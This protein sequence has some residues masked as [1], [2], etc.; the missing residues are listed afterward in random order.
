MIKKFIVV[1]LVLSISVLGIACNDDEENP[2]GAGV[3]PSASALSGTVATNSTNLSWTECPDDDFASY[4][5]YRSETSGIAA[6]PSAATMITTITDAQTLIYTDLNLAWE[7]NY[8]YAL[9]TVDSSQLT[10]WSNEISITTPDSSGGGGGSALTCY[11]IQGQA[12]E[13]PY[14]GEDV[15]VTG[16]VTAGGNEYYGGT[17]TA[18][19]AVIEDATGGEWSGLVLYGYDGILTG[20]VRG[21]SVVVSGYVS[22]YNGLTEV[23]VNTID[24]DDPGHT[25]PA[26]A[27]ISTVDVDLEKWEGVL[28]SVSNVTVTDDDLGYGEWYVD[29]GSGDGRV[30]DLGDYSYS[31]SNGDTFTEI[32]GVI[33][34]SFT[35]YKIEPRDDSDLI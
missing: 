21:D 16:I 18:Q 27:A 6:N 13:S 9:K 19:Y 28:I 32:I 2:Q 20:L 23:V 8:Y 7:T 3:N 24:F 30:D 10:S 25:I 12:D 11:Q 35:Y 33:F 34:Y 17:G 26:P 15:T 5:L 29:D 4:N 22:E 31:P 14:D 1:L